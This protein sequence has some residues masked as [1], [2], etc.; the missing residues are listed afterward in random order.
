MRK[1]LGQA[2]TYTKS[3][4][5]LARGEDGIATRLTVHAETYRQAKQILETH[6][7]TVIDATLNGL[8]VLQ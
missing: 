1:T 6:K 2:G 4:S 8:S 7:Y 3:Y 5:V